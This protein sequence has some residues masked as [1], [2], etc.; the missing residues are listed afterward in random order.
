M[1]NCGE[2]QGCK[3]GSTF[4]H[5]CNHH[6]NR[7]EKKNHVII[8]IDTDNIFYKIQHSLM[9]KTQKNRNTREFPQLDKNI[10]QKYTSNI[11]FN[12]GKLNVF[13][14]RLGRGYLC[15]SFLFNTVLEDLA[16]ATRK[17]K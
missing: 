1:T 5:Q 10:Y 13:S 4:K 8:S 3:I 16:S 11:I 7:L 6:V 12:C 17:E 15:L 9:I 14:F 2:F